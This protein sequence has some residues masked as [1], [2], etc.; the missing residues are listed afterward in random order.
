MVR[1]SDDEEEYQETGGEEEEMPMNFPQDKTTIPP[2]TPSV[3]IL[4]PFLFSFIL[5]SG[6]TKESI[7]DVV[8]NKAFHL[9]DTVKAKVMEETGSESSLFHS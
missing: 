7:K 1:R 5:F 8:V 4:F 2:S 6:T 3:S 9:K